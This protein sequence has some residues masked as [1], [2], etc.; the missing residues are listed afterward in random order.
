MSYIED[1]NPVFEACRKGDVGG[2][3]AFLDRGG[4]VYA[5]SARNIPLIATACARGYL[6]I[7][8]LLL[9]KGLDPNRPF[10]RPKETPLFQAVLYKQLEAAKQ[11]IKGGADVNARDE[12]D[13]VPIH[14][15]VANG[16]QDFF[17]LFLNSGADLE[18][19]DFQ[20]EMLI[21]TAARYN[22][23]KMLERLKQAR[24]K[25][26]DIV[27]NRRNPRRGDTPLSLAVRRGHLEA[28]D[29]LL[30]HGADPTVK[31]GLPMQ[32]LSDIARD[33]GHNGIEDLL[34]RYEKKN[35]PAG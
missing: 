11:L 3:E 6:D 12:D 34:Q 33:K 20:G 30:R 13:T 21:H 10:N 23:V 31:T 4:T 16:Q 28:A 19:V 27:N 35:Q 8:D 9:R 14:Y 15:V 22:Q 2:V 18:T 26:S 29:W 24:G 25:I 17:E 7:I 5:Q 32:S 1:S